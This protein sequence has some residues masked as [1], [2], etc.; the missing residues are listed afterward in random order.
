MGE[1]GGRAQDTAERLRDAAREA[2][3]ELGYSA[4]RVE[5]VVSRAGVSHGTFYTY[6]PNKAAILEALVRDTASRLEAVASASW[7]GPDVH[8]AVRAVIGK[9]L[10]VFAEEADVVAVWREAAAADASFRDLLREVRAGYV[11]RVAE[12]LAPLTSRDIDATVAA[13]A[14]V[15]MVEGY[16]V[17]RYATATSDERVAAVRTLAALWYGGLT[18]LGGGPGR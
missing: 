18:E 16:A 13:S 7:E 4:A 2:F 6:Y 1:R 11:E 17:E 5:D 9:F 8:A 12:Q 15:A 14:L 3:D 10:E